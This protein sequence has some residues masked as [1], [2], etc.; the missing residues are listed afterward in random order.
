MS[1]K[2]E[3]TEFFILSLRWTRGDVLT[4]WAPDNCGYVTAIDQAGRYP[5]VQIEANLAYYNNGETALA[6]PCAAVEAEAVRVVRG[7][8]LE[9]LT[10]KRFEIVLGEPGEK[11]DV[12]DQG[13]EPRPMGLRV[14]GTST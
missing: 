12:C 11:C 13:A 9:A 2:A 14:T 10:K 5:R 3:P 4:W 7:A 6:I 1:D 8:R